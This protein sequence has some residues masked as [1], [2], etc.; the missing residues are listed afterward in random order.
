MKINTKFLGEVEIIKEEIIT[1]DKGLPAFEEEKEFVII[2]FGQDTPFLTLQ[3]INNAEVGFIIANPFDFFSDYQV[4]VPDS[5]IEQL[6]IENEMDVSSYVLLT[7]K[8][9][10]KQ[11]TANLQGP[12]IINTK[13]NKGKQIV[14]VD[15]SYETRHLLFTE[16]AAVKE[17]K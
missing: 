2:R 9:P 14:L 5:V 7:V 11:T 10:F 4:K 13:Q 15:S 3:S 17:G 6:E 1:F 8:D 16:E 12:I